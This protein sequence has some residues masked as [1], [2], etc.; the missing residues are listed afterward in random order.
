MAVAALS[1]F[2]AV[3]CVEEEKYKPGPQDLEGCYGVYFPAQE[4]DVVLDPADELKATFLVS[5]MDSTGAV[6]VPFKVVDTAGVFNVPEIVFADQQGTI[7]IEVTFDKAAVG[8][9]YGCS[10]VIDDPEYA[11]KYTADPP[12]LE[13]TVVREKW[14]SLGMAKYSD[15]LITAGYSVG[16]QTYEVEAY[17]NDLT[18]GLYRF[19]NVWGKAYPWNEPGDWDDSEDIWF[20][21]HAE[22]PAKVYFETTYTGMDWGYGEIVVWSMA[23]YYLKAE[24]TAKA[25]SY[26]GTLT[27]GGV[28]TF[29]VSSLFF[30]ELEYNNG[31]LLTANKS[32]GFKI[33]LPGGVDV[34]YKLSVEAGLSENGALPFTVTRGADV[35]SLAYAIYEGALKVADVDL[36]TSNIGKGREEAAKE[37]TAD[38]FT[39]TMDATGVYTAI[40][41]GF[42]K[43]GVPQ[44]DDVVEFSYLAAADEKPVVVD[45][46]IEPTN[47][48]GKDNP[49]DNTLEWFVYGKEITD[50]KVNVILKEE[51]DA[52]PEVAEAALLELPSLDGESLALLNESYVDGVVK[53]L[54]PGTEYT[55]LVW[56]TN[57]YEEAYVV[58]HTK[59]TGK[60]EVKLEDMLGK[61]EVA[62]TS[63]WEGPLETQIWILEESDNAE[64]G[65][66]MFTAYASMLCQPPIYATLDTDLNTI[67]V[68]DYQS[69]LVDEEYGLEL[70]ISN[71]EDAPIVFNI[72]GNGKFTGSMFGIYYELLDGS[73]A[74]WYDMFTEASAVK[75]ADLEEPEAPAEPA[76]VKK[77]GARSNNP[78]V[79]PVSKAVVTNAG[80]R[81]VKAATFTVGEAPVKVRNPKARIR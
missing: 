15:D 37:V 65:N 7:E 43:D 8:V 38:E 76:A 70:F 11:S 79:A 48:Y 40:F 41:V 51:Y 45:A 58:K 63:Y 6:N 61:Y 42:D 55:L 57:G 31:A 14:N 59:T 64:N 75:V 10:V 69:F 78:A 3:S 4:K 32:G 50:A 34:D 54:V 2:A 9:N 66:V 18:K 53:G 22:N 21:V 1:V 30:A 39:V 24:D 36:Y 25:S 77:L 81:S 12:V 16:V 27:E 62:A 71:A 28:I 68:P 29:P 19:K 73:D 5:R 20:Y 67:T 17:E 46:G 56:A 80:G 52:D 35:D 74:S 72:I 33:I 26:Y 47:K 49:S 60:L 44:S 23:D 13:F